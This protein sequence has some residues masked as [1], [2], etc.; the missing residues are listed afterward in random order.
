VIL[1]SSR[2]LWLAAVLFGAAIG[3]SIF[4]YQELWAGLAALLLVASLVDAAA[5]TRLPAPAVARRAPN[6]LALGV[7]TEVVLRIANPTRRQMR[8]ELHDHHPATLESEGLPAAV[9]LKPGGWAEVRYQVRPVARGETR[10]GRTELRL[11]SPLGLWQVTRHAGEASAVRVYP[12]FRALAKYTLL[13]TDNRL[14]QIGVLQVRRRGE[15]TAFHQLREYRQGD[16]QR[17]VDWKAT[18]RTARLIAREY[19]EEKDQRVL[20]VIDCGRRMASKDD[21]LSHF[22]HTLNAALLLSHVA[23][24]QGDAVGL[25]TMGGVQ[26]YLEPRKSIGAVHAMLNR[27]YDLEPT[28][29]VPDYDHAA[30]EV[31]R[32]M[33]RRTLV[34]LLTNLRDE[35]DDTLL[36]ALRLL[37]TRHLVVLASLREAIITRALSARVDS[38]DR[39]VTHAAAAEYLALRERVFRRIGAAGVMALDVEPERLPISLVNRYL[40][41]KRE[42]RL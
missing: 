25:L 32:H 18:A 21:E 40:E 7:R 5:A 12:N 17:A 13:A 14:S 26:R 39:A 24:R 36:P 22:D 15:G 19:E 30:H 29:A 35:D 1:P 2:L 31:M 34:I 4:G 42:G 3:V 16:P 11:A 23:L 8:C 33:R 38:F 9:A 6:A 28:L 27:V 20:L 10:F 41:L 37:R